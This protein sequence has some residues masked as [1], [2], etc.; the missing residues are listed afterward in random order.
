[1]RFLGALAAVLLFTV[2]A[3]A[4]DIER[5]KAHYNAYCVACHSLTAEHKITA[6]SHQGIFGRKAGDTDFP[7][8]SMDLKAAGE[9]GLVWNDETMAAFLTNPK[10]FVGEFLGKK[11]AAIRM[12]YAGTKDPELSKDVVAYLKTVWE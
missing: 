4:G 12:A 1:M 7:R 10:G 8:Y 9:A 11:R 5:G 2:P 6:P 3:E